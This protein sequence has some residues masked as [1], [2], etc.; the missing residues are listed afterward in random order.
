MF[1]TT[2]HY[3]KQARFIFNLFH[4]LQFVPTQRLT[5]RI[6]FYSGT[7]APIQFGQRGT[8]QSVKMAAGG[9]SKTSVRMYRTVRHRTPQDSNRTMQAPVVVQATQILSYTGPYLIHDI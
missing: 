6:S 2:A 9:S 1:L 5:T 7:M 8:V 4:R 3:N